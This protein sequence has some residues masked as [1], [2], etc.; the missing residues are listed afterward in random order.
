MNNPTT[1]TVDLPPRLLDL[2]ESYVRARSATLEV[3]ALIDE[4]KTSNENAEVQQISRG[5]YR[6]RYRAAES[7]EQRLADL[8]L[9]KLIQEMR[10]LGVG[11]LG[12]ALNDYYLKQVRPSSDH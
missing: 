2:F 9:F 3:S 11:T 1:V 4:L 5:A 12:E 6:H 10:E 7:E 8:V